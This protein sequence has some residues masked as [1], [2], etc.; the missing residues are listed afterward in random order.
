MSRRERDQSGM[1]EETV[2][3]TLSG[4]SFSTRS[5]SELLASVKQKFPSLMC[6][7][8]E[9]KR[10]SAAAH[11]VDQVLC[12]SRN[13]KAYH[14]STGPLDSLKVVLETTLRY[15]V[16][17]FYNVFA[18]SDSKDLLC[19]SVLEKMA[20]EQNWM[21]CCGIS[22]VGS[23]NVHHKDAMCVAL[24]PN[25]YRH[26]NC[27][28]IFSKP[29]LRSSASGSS[30]ASTTKSSILL[31]CKSCMTLQYYLNSRKRAYEALSTPERVKRQSVSSI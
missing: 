16:Y 31:Q 14:K 19:L 23:L 29:G 9:V 30:S 5:L 6:V 21:I 24:P 22:D 18:L 15:T 3:K 7:I 1:D 13:R 17:I 12:I 20:D 2:K 27:P 28:M 11:G 10:G 8:E 25:S 26:K 4:E